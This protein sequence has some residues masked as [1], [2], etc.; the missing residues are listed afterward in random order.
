MSK[1][2]QEANVIPLHPDKACR[3]N[4]EYWCADPDGEYCGHPKALDVSP[5]G[6]NLNRMLGAPAYAP[7]EG[8]RPDPAFDLCGKDRKLWKK[9]SPERMPKKDG[10]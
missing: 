1:E 10:W 2:K 8:G 7:K 5:V 4:C 6:V 3:W 9:R